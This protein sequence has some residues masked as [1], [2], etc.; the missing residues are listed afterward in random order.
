[1]LLVNGDL[2]I[3]YKYEQRNKEAHIISMH[4]LHL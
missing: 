1:M 3:Y 4:H 2:V